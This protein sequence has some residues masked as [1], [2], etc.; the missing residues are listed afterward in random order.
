M[1]VWYENRDKILWPYQAV[2]YEPAW[3]TTE[4]GLNRIVIASRFGSESVAHTGTNQLVTPEEIIGTNVI[5]AESSFNPVRFEQVQIYTQ[6]VRT[7]AGYNPNEEH[8]LM[9]PSLR[10]A[11]DGGLCAA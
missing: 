5:P 1:V 11:A 2:R 4:T 6:P 9:A 7:N 8:A 3:P 10:S